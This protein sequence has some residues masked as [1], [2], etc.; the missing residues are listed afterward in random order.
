MPEVLSI[1]KL[2]VSCVECFVMCDAMNK[3]DRFLKT[4]RFFYL[5]IT[6]FT[7]V[8]PALAFGKPMVLVSR[9]IA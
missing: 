7:Q 9:I 6:A 2:I 1:G 3:P 5:S 8:K 4:V